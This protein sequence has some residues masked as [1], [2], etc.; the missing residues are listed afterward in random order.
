MLRRK[1]LIT[2]S[3]MHP[4]HER[5]A[6]PEPVY[7]LYHNFVFYW[8]VTCN[9]HRIFTGNRL[10]IFNIESIHQ[11]KPTANGEVLRHIRQGG[12]KMVGIIILQKKIL[13]GS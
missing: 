4:Q 2:K 12:Y 3:V 7:R 1:F 6:I 13:Q 5:M 10:A 9:I 11:A 8:N